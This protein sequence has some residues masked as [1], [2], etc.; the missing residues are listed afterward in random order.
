MRFGKWRRRAPRI[1]DEIRFH[2]DQLIDE[3]VARGMDR[4]E[5]ERRAFLEFGNAGAI[6]E[7]VRDVRGR[8][9]DD[10]RADVRYA[11]RTLRRKPGL[12]LIAVLTLGLGVGANAAVVSI[13]YGILLKPLPVPEPHQ[14]VNIVSPGPRSGPTNCGTIGRCEAVFSYPMFRDLE[15]VQ[16]VFTGLAAHSAFDV[17]VT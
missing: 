16:T 6:E 3:Y 5:A 2:R 8:R 14:L 7:A 11:V 15:R 4:N 9:L 1:S 13:V 10:C 17:N 12:A